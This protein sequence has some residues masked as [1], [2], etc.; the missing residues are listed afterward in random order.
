MKPI[1]VS[2]HLVGTLASHTYG[3][4]LAVALYFAY[5]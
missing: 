2:W 4:G 1:P 5:Y 3:L